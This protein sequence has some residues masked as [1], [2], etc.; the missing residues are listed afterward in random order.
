MINSIVKPLQSLLFLLVCGLAGQAF[1]ADYAALD[2]GF[3]DRLQAHLERVVQK[4]GLGKAA[5]EGRLAIALVDITDPHVP[6]VAAI[7]GDLMMYAASLPKIALLYAAFVEI[8]GGRLK[9]DAHLRKAL[10]AMIRYS[11]NDDATLVL[12][13]VGKRR[14]AQILQSEPFRFY[15]PARN[16]G[17]WVGKEYAKGVAFRRDPLHNIS[18]GA[19]V[20]QT[21]RFY[22]LLETR[23]LLT[24]PSLIAE[25]KGMLGD[26]GI[27]HKFVKG[28]KEHPEARIFRK[29]GTW[30]EWHADSALIEAGP[31]RYIAVALAQDPEGGRWI[32]QLIAPMHDLVV[33]RTYA[34]VSD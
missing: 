10:T 17:L 34:A 2:Q 24:S 6:H 19:T 5:K 21:A 32:E 9:L 20:L 1:G 7:N 25:M 15:D 16:G 26:S 33:V 31:Y 13:K 4:L 22:Y 8:E 23:Q 29:S 3:D 18:H 28:L 12:N 11:S 27:N 14:V 30:H